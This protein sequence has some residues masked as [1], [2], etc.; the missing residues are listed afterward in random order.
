MDEALD[1]SVALTTS[2]RATADA[3]SAVHMAPSFSVTAHP[4]PPTT[5]EAGP[6]DT[7]YAFSCCSED[8]AASSVTASPTS[9]PE[10]LVC[11]ELDQEGISVMGFGRLVS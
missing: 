10:V 8:A 6:L 11:A 2:L 7:L 9:S 1:K 4:S 5:A 3:A